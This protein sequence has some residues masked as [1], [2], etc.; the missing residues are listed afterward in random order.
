MVGGGAAEWQG[1]MV[2]QACSEMA[3]SDLRWYQA[4]QWWQVVWRP[5]QARREVRVGASDVQVQAEWYR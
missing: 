3:R 2:W 1:G 4:G 5:H